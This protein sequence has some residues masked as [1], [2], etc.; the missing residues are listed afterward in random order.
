MKGFP[1]H[2]NTK[3]DYEYVIKNFPRDE[4]E[5]KLKALLDHEY[6]WFTTGALQ[7][8]ET[9]IEDDTHRT[10]TDEETGT[11][12]QQEFQINPNSPMKR[13]GFTKEEIES[14]LNA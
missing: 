6:D 13:L 12:Y 8:G 10:F 1:K 5:G 11:S 7:E 3:E 9:G 14:Y 2:L 4:W